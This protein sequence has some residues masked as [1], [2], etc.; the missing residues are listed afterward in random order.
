MK[1]TNEHYGPAVQVISPFPPLSMFDG[2][3]SARSRAKGHS[4]EVI[5][6]LAK[7]SRLHRLELDFTYFVNNNPLELSIQGLADDKWTTLVDKTNV[8]AYAANKIVFEIKDS[9]IFTQLKVTAHPDGGINRVKAF[10]VL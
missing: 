5:I 10:T 4:E 7:P 6:G 8:K 2:M 9:Q 3:E 1:A